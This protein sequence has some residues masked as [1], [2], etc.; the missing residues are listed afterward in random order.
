LLRAMLIPSYYKTT[1]PSTNTT[2]VDTT[3]LNLSH[4]SAL[5]LIVLITHRPEAA[6]EAEKEFSD[7]SP[8]T[9]LCL[10][11]IYT[12]L[13]AVFSELLVGSIDGFTASANISKSFVGIILL[14]IVGNAV[15]H[16]TAVRVAYKNNMELAMGVAVGSAT[17]I[18]LMV[19]PVAVI[20]G[21]IMDQPM[22]LAFNGFEAMTYLFSIL[23]VYVVVSDGSSNWLEGS[24]LLTIYG[25]IGLALLEIGD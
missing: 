9:A 8:T 6:E 25:L 23:I 18:S 24:V 10:L 16:V 11:L 15:E 1:I 4:I 20:A 3:I 19:V 7:I 17:Q 5:F 12:C 21:W 2:S 13:V 22:T 14:P